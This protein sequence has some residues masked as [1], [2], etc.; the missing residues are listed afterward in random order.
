[1]QRFLKYEIDRYLGGRSGERKKELPLVRVE[2]QGYIHYNKASVIFYALQDYAGEANINR[3]LHEYVQA[4][5]YQDPPYTFSPELTTRLRAVMPQPYLY[6]IGDMLESI[7]LFENRAVSATAKKLPDGS[8][9][10]TLKVKAR[11]VRAGELGEE[12]E[13]PLADWIDIGVL[14]EKGKPLYME[15]KMIDHPEM[16]FNLNVKGVPA[17]AGIDPWNKLVDRDPKDNTTK[18]AL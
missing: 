4:V 7:T 2:N 16:E 3:A 6:M 13:L 1:M 8:Y 9:A 5:A 18:V 10:V 17:T 15:R 14:D 11:K 12:K